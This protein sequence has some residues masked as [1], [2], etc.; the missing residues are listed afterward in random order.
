MIVA[1][2]VLFIYSATFLLVIRMAFFSQLATL[3]YR[4]HDHGSNCS[5]KTMA[6]LRHAL[7][8]DSQDIR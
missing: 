4:N 1:L 8:S 3:L 7:E 2:V 6:S 5:G